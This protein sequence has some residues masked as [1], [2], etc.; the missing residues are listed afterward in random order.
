V[1]TSEHIGNEFLIHGGAGYDFDLGG[2]LIGPVGSI[3]YLALVE[4]GFVER[5][6]G[7]ANLVID[8]RTTDSFRTIAGLRAAKQFQ[9]KT[10]MI[11]PEAH[12][13]WTHEWL[14]NPQTLQAQFT[15][16][17]G[18]AFGIVSR[19]LP[20]DGANVGFGITGYQ[21]EMAFNISYQSEFGRSDFINHVFDIGLKMSFF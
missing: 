15:G 20:D 21:H 18:P 9:F 7:A 11:V 13:K 6:A 5:G 10:L 17:T 14:D 3:E 2:L 1:A 16:I 8:G 4:D 12:A 19:E